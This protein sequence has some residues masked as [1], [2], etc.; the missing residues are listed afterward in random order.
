[1]NLSNEAIRSFRLRAHHLDRKLPAGSL[2]QAAG[3]CGVQNSPP[4]A[5]E[6]SLFL[7]VAGCTLESLRDALYRNKK[8]LQ[9]W[10]F[11]GVPTVF[12]TDQSRIF[13]SALVSHPG[14]QPWIY[15]RGVSAALEF[16]R[17]EF[18]ELLPLVI[19]TAGY[20]DNHTVE[21][22]EALDRILAGLVCLPRDRQPLW[23]A[24][25]PYGPGQT[26]GGAIVSFLLRPCSFLSLVVFGERRGISP[27]FTSFR[28]WT[29]S[30]PCEQPEAE[31][32]LVRKFLHCY[33]PS[34][35]AAFLSWLGC[36]PKQAERLW[37]T[38]AEE[39]EPVKVQGKTRYLLSADREEL[40]HAG[41]AGGSLLLLG[42]HDPYLELRDRELLLEDKV[43]QQ[44][45]WRTVSNPGVILKDGRIAG[46]WT[47]RAAKGC[48][49][50]CLTPWESLQPPER[51]S[52]ERSAE[53]YAAFRLLRL[54]TCAWE[55]S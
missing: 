40:L 11:R 55:N 9:A 39:T 18:D 19:Q 23:D 45:V 49:E 48:L 4:G 34:T 26:V 47:A 42:P 21:S 33:G 52:L 20:L 17:M 8:L 16:V 41:Q 32:E 1:M 5:W 27:T 25:S 50:V 29:G 6:T 2:L 13:L 15:T 30:A 3:A 22:K 28:N 54:K 14:E 37:S 36:S 7:R 12:P 51:R 24:P 10:S 38:A 44:A 46:I 31:K 35:K 43:R 53:E